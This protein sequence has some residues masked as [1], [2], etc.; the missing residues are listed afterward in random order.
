VIEEPADEGKTISYLRFKLYDKA[1]PYEETRVHQITAKV[2]HLKTN[3]LEN[4]VP[5]MFKYPNEIPVVQE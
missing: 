2:S 5:A 1:S 4:P 3:N